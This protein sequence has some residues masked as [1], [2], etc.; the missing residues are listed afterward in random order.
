M[1]DQQMFQFCTS[2]SECACMG[3]SSFENQ[4]S[5]YETP[6][7]QIDIAFDYEMWNLLP[8]KWRPRRLMCGVIRFLGA[9][10]F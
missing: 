9:G 10:L 8:I 5:S 7:T 4:C 1:A 6:L 3:V 2:S